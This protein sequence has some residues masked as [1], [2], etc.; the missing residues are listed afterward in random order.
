MIRHNERA[1]D[2]AT[3]ATNMLVGSRREK[4]RELLASEPT[5]RAVVVAPSQSAGGP[6]W[7]R[8]MDW[9]MTFG[10]V[11]WITWLREVLQSGA[12]PSYTYRKKVRVVLR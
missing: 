7:H 5:T 11:L 9:P 10:K 2:P 4:T 12:L 6:T 8:W 1:T 3:E